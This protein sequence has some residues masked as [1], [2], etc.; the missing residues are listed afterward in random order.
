MKKNLFSMDL[1]FFYLL[2]YELI[3]ISFKPIVDYEENGGKNFKN[4]HCSFHLQFILCCLKF[5]IIQFK[6]RAINVTRLC[7][8]SLSLPVPFWAQ[9]VVY[10]F[11]PQFQF[12]F[13]HSLRGNKSLECLNLI[14]LRE[15]EKT[16]CVIFKDHKYR[17][18]SEINS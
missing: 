3:P 16:L 2:L 18:L 6:G 1:C 11:L 14:F 10:I 15:V 12:V 5:H 7:V 13:W 4:D 9:N 17:R 8:V